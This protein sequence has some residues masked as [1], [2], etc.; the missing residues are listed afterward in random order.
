[1]RKQVASTFE[2]PLKKALSD[3]DNSPLEWPGFSFPKPQF[4]IL[5]LKLDTDGT[6]L[7]VQWLG[8]WASTSGGMGLIP[9]WG[10]KILQ[11]KIKQNNFKK[12]K[13][14]LASKQW[15]QEALDTPPWTQFCVHSLSL[16][17]V[18]IEPWGVVQAP[19][20]WLWENVWGLPGVVGAQMSASA[21]LTESITINSQ[22]NT[23]EGFS[24]PGM[25]HL[26]LPVT[27]GQ[28]NRKR[29]M[30]WQHVLQ[31]SSIQHL[32]KTYSLPFC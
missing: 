17:A 1:M 31:Y 22:M 2:S 5:C 8:L 15:N 13:K 6:S 16:P 23:T 27:S 21:I 29:W 26:K 14:K 3:L 7:G 9:G 12:M 28:A 19:P 25:S 11:A 30:P 18:M 4:L 10:T 32:L 20:R 24:K